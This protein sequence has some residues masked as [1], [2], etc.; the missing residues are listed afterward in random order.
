[1]EEHVISR[2]AKDESILS[3]EIKTAMVEIRKLRDTKSAMKIELKAIEDELSLRNEKVVDFFEAH[4]L[5]SLKMKGVGNFFLNREL[6]PKVVDKEIVVEWLKKT[7]DLD[8]IMTFNT[9]KF[10]AYYKE[11]LENKDS[12]PEGVEAFTKTDIRVRKA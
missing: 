11:R 12:L 4:K 3:D 6:Y 10:K 5:Q 1:M 9:N 2:T 8:L 7:G